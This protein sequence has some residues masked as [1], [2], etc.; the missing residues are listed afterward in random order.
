MK[1]QRKGF[2]VAYSRREREVHRVARI[3]RMNQLEQCYRSMY[4]RSGLKQY[5]S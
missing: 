4:M 3:L 2:S 1:I 5:E